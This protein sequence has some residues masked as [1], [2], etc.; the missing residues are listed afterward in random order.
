MTHILDLQPYPG[1]GQWDGVDAW[2]QWGVLSF[3]HYGYRWYVWS[4]GYWR[5]R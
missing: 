1:K 5:D 2:T 3:S 4:K